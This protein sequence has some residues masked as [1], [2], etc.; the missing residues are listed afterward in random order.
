GLMQIAARVSA[1]SD[2]ITNLHFESVRLAPVRIELVPPLIEVTLPLRH[3]VMALRRGVIEVIVLPVVFR[4]VAGG[5]A[6]A[7]LSHRD[8]PIALRDRGVARATAIGGSVG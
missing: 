5:R 1:R 7:R 3:A 4:D 2:D 8:M 6:I